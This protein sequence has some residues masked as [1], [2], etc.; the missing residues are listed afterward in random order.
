MAKRKPNITGAITPKR[1]RQHPHIKAVRFE[2]DPI[3][4]PLDKR[5]VSQEEGG[6]RDLPSSD[7]NAPREL[8]CLL[9]EQG[10][11][12]RHGGVHFVVKS[13]APAKI[14]VVKCKAVRS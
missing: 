5:G 8:K 3:P 7:G 9:C 10:Y 12:V 1:W 6:V 13:I 11:K 4:S 14:D 2:P